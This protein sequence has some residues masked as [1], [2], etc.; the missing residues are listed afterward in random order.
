MSQLSSSSNQEISFASQPQNRSPFRFF[1]L[2]FALSIP[3][4]LVGSFISFEI[5]PGLPLSTL[6]II[7]PITA[8]LILVY[9]ESKFV[10]VT[11]LLKRAFDYKRVNAKLW[12]LPVFLL[13]PGLATLSWGVMRFL[14]RSVPSPQFSI[15]TALAMLVAFFFAGLGE[16]LGWTGYALDPLQERSTALQASLIL[17]LVGAAWHIT[18]LVQVGRSPSWIAWWCLGTVAERVLSVWLYNNTGRSVFAVAITHATINLS[19]QLFPINGS[20]YDP[21]ITSLI[22][23]LIAIII[24][25]IWGPTNLTRSRN[26][27]ESLGLSVN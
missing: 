25:L 4:W 6:N 19:W 8:A 14:G 21:Q 3:I 23:A 17:G 26:V 10:G 15:L 1:L 22:T 5:L 2:V 16:E 12:Y 7:I 18:P 13:I 27:S 24:V 20:Y 11:K 9:R